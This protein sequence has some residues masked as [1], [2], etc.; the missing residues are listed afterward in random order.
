M[1]ETGIGA[2]IQQAR[3]HYPEF[4]EGAE[5][6]AK[7]FG[8]LYATRASSIMIGRVLTHAVFR[9]DPRYFYKGTGSVR[10]RVRYAI[11]AIVICKGDNGRWQPNYS[12]VIGNFASGALSN[13][14][15]PPA[16]RGIQLTLV[17]AVLATASGAVNNLFQE[18]LLK[19][20]STGV[21]HTTGP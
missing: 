19:K 17:N 18:F 12:S 4:G 9:Q 1:L 10:S 20:I 13:S 6:Y 21:S 16:N 3:D 15:Y 14:Y 2:G 8:A 5:G 11:F 7:R